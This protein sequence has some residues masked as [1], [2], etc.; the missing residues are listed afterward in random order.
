MPRG[1]TSLTRSRARAL[2]CRAVPTDLLALQFPPAQF[3]FLGLCLAGQFPASVEVMK[4]VGTY[5]QTVTK[6][7]L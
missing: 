1:R 2:T 4:Y 7:S 5:V 6:Y 3:V